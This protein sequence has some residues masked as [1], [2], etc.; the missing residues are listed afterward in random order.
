MQNVARLCSKCPP[1]S[2]LAG[3]C[4][5][6]AGRAGQAT[7]GAA[8]EPP[9]LTWSARTRGQLL[10]AL[11]QV[12]MLM[13]AQPAS[14]DDAMGRAA[15][16]TK[17]VQSLGHALSL[18]RSHGLSL[19]NDLLAGI[20]ELVS[21]STPVHQTLLRCGQTALPL[22]VPVHVALHGCWLRI[23]GPCQGSSC[24][25]CAHSLP[26]PERG[27]V[28][29]VCPTLLRHG[30]S[31]HLARAAMGHVT[32]SCDLSSAGGRQ[33][34]LCSLHTTAQLTGMAACFM[35]LWLVHQLVPAQHQRCMCAAPEWCMTLN[36]KP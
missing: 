7:Q 11:L 4:A 32:T 8:P 22:A 14:E 10:S 16:Y 27:L 17:Y 3:W 2:S 24:G 33:C 20:R 12:L 13:R 1:H 28:P 34:L 23:S 25:L 30:C 18:A 36:P 6:P 31:S 35:P 21:V 9:T 19:L 5:A 15:L 29:G 26:P